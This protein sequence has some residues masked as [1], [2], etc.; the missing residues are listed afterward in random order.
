[1]ERSTRYLKDKKKDI[2]ILGRVTDTVPLPGYHVAVKSGVE[3]SFIIS[4]II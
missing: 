4:D 2:F 3:L 1:M